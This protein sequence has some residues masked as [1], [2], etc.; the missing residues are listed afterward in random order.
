MPF[1]RV[2]TF[3]YIW[4]GRSRGR[5]RCPRW[6]ACN[7]KEAQRRGMSCAQAILQT[8]VYHRP[9]ELSRKSDS[10]RWTQSRQSWGN[11]G[12][13]QHKHHVWIS[14]LDLVS[15]IQFVGLQRNKKNAE[16]H[17]IDHP[18]FALQRNI[19]ASFSLCIWHPSPRLL[20]LHERVRMSSETFK[21]INGNLH[22]RE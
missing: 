20:I 21:R 22:D 2:L 19:Y 1:N 10:T 16:S 3:R 7:G 6:W 18:A 11:Q 13:Q 4:W 15:V 5:V 14:V 8:I 12:R 17:L 9:K